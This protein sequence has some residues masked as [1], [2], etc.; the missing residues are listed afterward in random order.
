MNSAHNRKAH[1]HSRKMQPAP[2]RILYD[3]PCKVCRDHSSG[4]HYG[5]FACDGCAGFFKRS[6]RRNRQYVCKAKS[7][8]GCMVDKTHRNQ[9]RACRLKKCIHA[10]MNK[11]AVQ[12]ERGPR[13]S[14]LR[15]QMSMFF[16]EPGKDI[17]LTATMISPPPVAVLNLALPKNSDQHRTAIAGQYGS[18]MHAQLYCGS[19]TMPQADHYPAF[20]PVTIPVIPSTQMVVLYSSDATCE[21]AARVLFLNVRWTKDLA[22]TTG[23]TMDDQLILLEASWR[24]LF[25]LAVAQ[26]SPTLDPTALLSEELRNTP[27]ALEVLR[28][29]EVLNAINSVG[30]NAHEFAC[31]RAIVYF[32]S[33]L[34]D[35]KV[36]PSSRNS[37]GS[38]S[39]PGTSNMA[40]GYH[41]RDPE[42]IARL[43]DGAY[44][45]LGQILHHASFGALRFGRILMVL[46]FLKS[47][48]SGVIEELFFR[49]TIGVIPIERIICDVYK[50]Q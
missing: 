50:S 40:P 26:M 30:M 13:N 19:I 5:I 24:D 37:D 9:C 47:V 16:K 11:E 41:A 25:L 33:I 31:V 39:P 42:T 45:A 7:T 43:R 4:K 38:M 28:F 35:L 3:I 34:E 8:G 49:R 48:S 46:P 22:I 44:L 29:R 32:S 17:N 21:H 23:L 12:H 36:H 20:P 27:L 14:T 6:I 1:S 10:G 2:S 15:R 18:Q